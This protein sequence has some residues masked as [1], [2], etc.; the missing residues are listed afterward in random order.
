MPIALSDQKYLFFQ[1]KRVTYKYV[2]MP[3]GL[4]SAPTIFKKLLKLVLSTLRTQG[5]QAMNYL[6]DFFLVGDNFEESRGRFC[7]FIIKTYYQDLLLCLLKKTEYL[8]FTM[9]SKDM[10]V[11]LTKEK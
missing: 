7:R 2:R 3:N 10:T 11:T 4:S 8:G 6:D 9:N 5:H 1:F